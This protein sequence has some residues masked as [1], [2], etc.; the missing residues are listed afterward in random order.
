MI[1]R[2]FSTDDI[3]TIMHQVDVICDQLKIEK[4]MAFSKL[5]D[6]VEREKHVMEIGVG[7]VWK[8]P[9]EFNKRFGT[10]PEDGS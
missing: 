4:T 6:R 8:S 7:D 3:D 2:D 10:N 9:K 1:S 5:V